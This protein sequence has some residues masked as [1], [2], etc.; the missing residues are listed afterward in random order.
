MPNSTTRLNRNYEYLGGVLLLLL[1]WQLLSMHYNQVLVPSPAETLQ[2]LV[3]LVESGEL[4][5]NLLITFHRQLA[6]LAA[7]ISIGMLSGLLAG[8]FRRLDLLVQPLIN[9][10]LAVPAII[11][12]TMAMVW[13]GMGTTMTV[14]LV[15]LLV[16]PVIH[17]NAA[18]GL[19]AIDPALLEM[20]E[21][22][23]LPPLLKVRKIYLPGMRHA[24]IAGFSL[25]MASSVRLTVMAELLGA[26]E[27]MGQRIA[28]ARVYL[29]TER[30]F[31]WVLVLL[32]ILISLEFLFIRP[33]KR[34]AGQ[35]Q[36]EAGALTARQDGF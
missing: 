22:Y 3:S 2:A 28:I 17:T 26:R 1:G 32:V 34:W 10:L 14:F 23:R 18:E 30:L 7:G 12:V 36:M 29:E 8:C 19:K 11:F 31:A 27:G 16:F 5:E 9:F 33:L 35:G 24:L 13:F 25:A 4:A 21:V 15:S 6:G 20:A